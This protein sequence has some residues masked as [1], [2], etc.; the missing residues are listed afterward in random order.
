[1]NTIKRVTVDEIGEDFFNFLASQSLL[2]ERYKIQLMEKRNE[3]AR[4]YRETR[5]A[6]LKAKSLLISSK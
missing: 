3:K 4:T 6:K 5:D 1:M 2:H